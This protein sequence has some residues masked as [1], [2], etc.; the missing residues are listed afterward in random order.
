MVI[1][2]FGRAR[3]LERTESVVGARRLVVS[4]SQPRNVTGNGT[5]RYRRKEER[6][7]LASTRAVAKSASRFLP[8]LNSAAGILPDAS[9]FYLEHYEL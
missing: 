6:L 5:P 4:L 2:S 8:G 1:E 7:W 9:R 3:D